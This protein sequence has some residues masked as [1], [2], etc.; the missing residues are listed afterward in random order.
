M[1]VRVCVCVCV[2]Q[3]AN[4]G[5]EH[6]NTT[7]Q[8]KHKKTKARFGCLARSPVWKRSRPYFTAPGAHTGQ[9]V[10]P[11]DSLSVHNAYVLLA[12]PVHSREWRHSRT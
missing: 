6:K 2:R 7:A 3:R 4:I 10:R 5:L 9:K 11:T 1:C 8:N 12:H